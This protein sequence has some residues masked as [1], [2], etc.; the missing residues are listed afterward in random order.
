M[1]LILCVTASYFETK[2]IIK[3]NPLPKMSLLERGKTG[4]SG[5]SCPL[6]CNSYN[7]VTHSGPNSSSQATS[8][9]TL[10][11]VTSSITIRCQEWQESNYTTQ[12]KWLFKHKMVMVIL[13][14]YNN[15]SLG[16]CV[17]WS[18]TL[19]GGC[20]CTGSPE[21]FSSPP[22]VS[23]PDRHH[24]TCVTHVPW[25]MRSLTSGFHWSR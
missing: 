12:H 5:K 16:N 11:D 8:G 4:T 9:N 7:G 22:Q 19:F 2:S 24:S 10:P 17:S 25:C 20:A 21:T 15:G 14:W 3:E 6:T 23:D 18:P 13:I 1:L